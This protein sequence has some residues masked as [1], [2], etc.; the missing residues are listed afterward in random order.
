M[1]FIHKK[2][3]PLS[4]MKQLLR[5]VSSKWTAICTIFQC[6]INVPKEPFK[7]FI[8]S[9][10]PNGLG[11]RLRL[12]EC[13]KWITSFQPLSTRIKYTRRYS[14]K[15]WESELNG[16]INRYT[17]NYS[18]CYSQ[19]LYTVGFTHTEWLPSC[20]TEAFQYHLCSTY[21]GLWGPVVVQLS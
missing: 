12:Y 13:R 6:T 11:T 4:G 16:S 1:I 5:Q 17:R 8:S 3:L 18:P 20:A 7:G 14:V 15:R 19:A 9:I 10:V 21:R 2:S